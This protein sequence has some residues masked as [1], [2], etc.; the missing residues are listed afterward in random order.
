[1]D[2]SMPLLNGYESTERIREVEKESPPSPENQRLSFALNGRIPI[3]AVS[4]SLYEQ[5]RS[6][7]SDAGMDGWILKPI[8]FK[9]LATI[10]KGVT[11]LTQRECDRYRSGY[12]WEVGGWLALENSSG[13]TSHTQDRVSAE[14]INTLA[15]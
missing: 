8:D 15:A 11:D 4:A 5:Q 3:L 14:G 13:H 6:K 7:L 10:L 12:N 1:M 2:L 9:R